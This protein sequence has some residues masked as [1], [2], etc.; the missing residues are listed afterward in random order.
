MRGVTQFIMN[1]ASNWHMVSRRCLP[2]DGLC[3]IMSPGLVSNA[4][5]IELYIKLLALVQG[6]QPLSG[7]DHSE[8]FKKLTKDTQSKII[9]RF[10]S[11]HPY[12]DNDLVDYLQETGTWFVD[13]RYGFERLA[14]W[15]VGDPTF[16][17]AFNKHKYWNLTRSFHFTVVEFA[18]HLDADGR[19]SATFP[20]NLQPFG[21]I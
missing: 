20:P 19:I 8:M 5:S 15:K 3:W 1:E 6:Q 16:I 17:P 10:A 9:A 7:H 18:P 21:P 11:Y 4:F 14:V 13:V 12:P 2:D